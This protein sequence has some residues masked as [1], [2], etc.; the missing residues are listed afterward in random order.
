[1]VSGLFLWHT[2]FHCY[3]YLFFEE[4]PLFWACDMILQVINSFAICTNCFEKCTNCCANVSNDVKRLNYGFNLYFQTIFFSTLW[5][6][7]LFC[8]F[9]EDFHIDDFNFLTFTYLL[10]SINSYGG[11]TPLL[12]LLSHP[13]WQINLFTSCHHVTKRLLFYIYSSVHRYWAQFLCFKK[14]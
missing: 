14:V 7:T 3:E 2:H 12:R 5:K 9:V 1:M 4:W 10:S 11:L 8:G 13:S 6:S